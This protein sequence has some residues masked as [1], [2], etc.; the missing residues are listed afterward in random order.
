M[1]AGHL[2]GGKFNALFHIATRSCRDL[3]KEEKSGRGND[4]GLTGFWSWRV[5]QKGNWSCILMWIGIKNSSEFPIPNRLS[6]HPQSGQASLSELQ[7]PSDV[8]PNL[9]L[10][11]C[12]QI[13]SFWVWIWSEALK[14]SE[15][16]S[17]ENWKDLKSVDFSN[18]GS[19]RTFLNMNIT[20]L[21]LFF[22]S[23]YPHLLLTH[24]ILR[25][26]PVEVSFFPWYWSESTH[27]SQ[28]SESVRTR[29]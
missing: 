14:P 18:D 1:C 2:K 19:K 9:F 23:P 10:P 7:K 6:K 29:K 20:I 25:N 16:R 15:K 26:Y 4:S 13:Y 28:T 3:R 8:S 27:F 24:P 11:G 12:N 17:C 5:E 21:N 22:K